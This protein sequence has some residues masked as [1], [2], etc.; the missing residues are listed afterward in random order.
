MCLNVSISYSIKVKSRTCEL[1]MLKKDDFLKVSMRYREYIHKFLQR[2][3]MVYMRYNDE[4]KKIINDYTNKLQNDDLD[5]IQE[6]DSEY[7]I[8]S[9]HESQATNSK[10][11]SSAGSEGA[12]NKKN[13]MLEKLQQSPNPKTKTSIKKLS[14]TS[15]T[16]KGI[17]H[18]NSA[19]SMRKSFS[20]PIKGRKMTPKSSTNTINNDQNE[21]EVDRHI[22][23]IKDELYMKFSF[24]IEKILKFFV[25]KGITFNH[26]PDN[27]NPLTLLKQLKNIREVSERN[28]LIE[29]LEMSVSKLM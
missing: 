12:G 17:S 1:F 19:K 16:K 13:S 22:E 10:E 4:I 5:E 2:S 20:P 11:A 6:E 18:S 29:R 25:D 24:K 15:F 21:F 3:L 9:D 14:K 28:D 26:L 7:N 8:Y 23:I 27:E